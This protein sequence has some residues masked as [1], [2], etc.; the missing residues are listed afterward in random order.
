MESVDDQFG[1]ARSKN[2][3]ERS[4][5]ECDMIRFSDQYSG[6]AELAGETA[7]DVQLKLEGDTLPTAGEADQK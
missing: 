5:L 6:K 1:S 4:I 7:E 3:I 2:Q